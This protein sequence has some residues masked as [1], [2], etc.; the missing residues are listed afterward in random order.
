MPV[1]A[2]YPAT[3]DGLDFSRR[4]SGRPCPRSFFPAGMCAQLSQQAGQILRTSNGM[5]S[6]H[7]TELERIADL[8]RKWAHGAI[9]AV[10]VSRLIAVAARIAARRLGGELY[11]AARG[12]GTSPESLAISLITPLFGEP[13]GP[14]SEMGKAW[15]RNPP[16]DN[17][18]AVV[19]WLE[20]L[21][22][23]S[24][25]RSLARRDPDRYRSRARVRRRL[26]AAIQ[27][28][29]LVL[30]IPPDR[31]EYVRLR[32]STELH[33][34]KRQVSLGEVRL[35]ID[36]CWRNDAAHAKNTE[37]V[38]SFLSDL[39]DRCRLIPFALLLQAVYD[40]EQAI[41]TDD[42]EWR[43]QRPHPDLDFGLAL[44]ETIEIALKSADP[45]L[46]HYLTNGKLTGQQSSCMRRG[47]GQWIRLRVTG[48]DPVQ[49]ECLAEFWPGLTREEYRQNQEIRE[50]FEYIVKAAWK[51]FEDLWKRELGIR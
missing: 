32:I 46:G 30:G 25:I 37:V 45:I 10:E 29:A 35:A 28:S 21:V 34:Q 17:P 36:R 2:G 27:S 14:D 26:R 15:R 23:V 48:Q 33:C 18:A 11:S 42:L 6:I 9:S 49:H 50:R 24:S 5:T 8:V 39:P 38:V 47:A 41:D 12:M 44:D 3:P 40:R 7:A 16:D 4:V 20:S 19:A 13:P 31:P 51:R 22:F 43:A 1:S